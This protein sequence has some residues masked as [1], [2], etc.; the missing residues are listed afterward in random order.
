MAELQSVTYKQ[1]FEIEVNG[2][3]IK[4]DD[5]KVDDGKV[6]A[7]E[8]LRLAKQYGAMPGNPD[9]YQLQGE[10]R[11]Y[12]ADDWVDLREDKQFI[13]IPIGPTDVA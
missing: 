9:D 13:T 12:K 3:L 10:Q 5:G 8:I 11:L 4:V 1:T 2:V 6:R 7:D